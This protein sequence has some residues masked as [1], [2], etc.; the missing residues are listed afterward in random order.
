VAP[1]ESFSE[2]FEQVTDSPSKFYFVGVLVSII[3]LIFVVGLTCGRV[4]K[5]VTAE[6]KNK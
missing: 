1:P 2:L 4:T 3:G 6:N 5:R